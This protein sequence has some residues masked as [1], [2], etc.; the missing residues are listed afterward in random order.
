VT[1]TVAANVTS[2]L[3]ARVWVDG[4]ALGGAKVYPVGLRGDWHGSFRIPK[5]GSPR[6][7][8]AVGDS[9]TAQCERRGPN[10]ELLEILIVYYSRDLTVLPG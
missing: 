10:G 7:A 1:T 4:F 3:Q 2:T 5:R 9:I 8:N 6:P